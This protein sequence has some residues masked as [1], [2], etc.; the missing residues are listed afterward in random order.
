MGFRVTHSFLTKLYFLSS[1]SKYDFFTKL[2]HF[3]FWFVVCFA[4]WHVYEPIFLQGLFIQSKHFFKRGYVFALHFVYGLHPVLQ[5]SQ[6]RW[7]PF[8][9]WLVLEL[10]KVFK[11]QEGAGVSS[12][13]FFRRKNKWLRRSIVST[14]YFVLNQKVD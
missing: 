2:N 4:F 5:P 13:C 12:Q 3:D 14:C 6:L 8:E 10:Q 9:W 1:E 11:R 7:K